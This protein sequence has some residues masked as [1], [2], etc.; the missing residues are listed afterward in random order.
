MDVTV[1]VAAVITIY[2]VPAIIAAGRKH[3]QA[4]A[5]FVLNLLAGWTVLGWIVA[6]VWACTAVRSTAAA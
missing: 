3:H 5:I 1:V 6:V 4:G 2:F